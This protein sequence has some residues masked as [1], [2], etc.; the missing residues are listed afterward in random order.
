MPR[1]FARQV[2]HCVTS[3]TDPGAHTEIPAVSEASTGSKV[4]T[5]AGSGAGAEK[6]EESL[7]ED[8]ARVGGASEAGSEAEATKIHPD[9]KEKANKP[10]KKSNKEGAATGKN[11]VNKN[12]ANA[13][14]AALASAANRAK[15]LAAKAASGNEDADAQFEK[16]QEQ[17]AARNTRMQWCELAG[18][19]RFS[20]REDV[21]RPISHPGERVLCAV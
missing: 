12:K 4:G 6:Y 1:A 19:S 2:R 3:V 9:K 20:S 18:F 13:E 7:M 10:I 8:K 21:L 11:A 15:Q 5:E 14:K 17:L 16:Y